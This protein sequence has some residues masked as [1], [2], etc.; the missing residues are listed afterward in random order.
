[1]A[2]FIQEALD[3]RLMLESILMCPVLGLEK[4][5]L[6]LMGSLKEVSKKT[7]NGYWRKEVMFMN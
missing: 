1:M 4:L 6:L 7:A 5:F 3:A 2:S